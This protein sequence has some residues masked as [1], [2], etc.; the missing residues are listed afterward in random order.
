MFKCKECGNLFEEGEQKKWK[1]PHGEELSGCPI[2]FSAYVE[3]KQC[4]LCGE[5]SENKFCDDCKAYYKKDFKA[6]MDKTYD[7]NERE[8]INELFDGEEL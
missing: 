1:E 2:C 5:Y 4:A 3:V 6:L 7:N 8:L